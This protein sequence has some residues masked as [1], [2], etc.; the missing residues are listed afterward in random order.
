VIK[1]LEDTL[2]HLH[3]TKGELMNNSRFTN[4]F[5]LAFLLI[6]V[7]AA[8]SGCGSNASA[9]PTPQLAAGTY[10]NPSS[11]YGMEVK[12][13][14]DGTYTASSPN[15]LIPIQGT[16]VATEDQIVFTETKDGHCIDI[17]GTYKWAFDGETLTFTV[18]EDQCSL[19]RI[20][21]QS[22]PWITQP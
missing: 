3:G 13:L 4:S 18:V 6:T 7:N 5:F 2:P 22:G 8:V 14:E 11:R 20:A 21:L 9:T 16:Y 15:A 10:A 12:L 17:P 1:L 19:R